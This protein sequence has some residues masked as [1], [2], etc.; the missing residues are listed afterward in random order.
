MKLVKEAMVN[1][2]VVISHGHFRPLRLAW[3]GLASLWLRYGVVWCGV[4]S[5]SLKDLVGTGDLGNLH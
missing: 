5:E 4:W 1:M 3:F 2:E